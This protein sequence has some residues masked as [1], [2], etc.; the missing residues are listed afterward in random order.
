MSEQ[1]FD[2]K[3][4]IGGSDIAAVLGLSRWCTPLKLWALKTGV[5]PETDLSDNEAVQTGIDLE[6]YVAHRFTKATGLKLRRDSRTV[7][8]AKYDFLYGHVDRILIGED[9]IYEGKTTSAYNLK[10][11]ENGKM[12]QEYILQTQFYCGLWKK[13]T[14][15]LSCLIGGQ[16]YRWAKIDFDSELF[17]KMIESAATFWN[18]FVL[19]KIAPMACADDNEETIDLLY[20]KSGEEILNLHGEQAQIIDQLVE[21]RLGGLEQ[22]KLIQEELDKIEAQ[23]KMIIGEAEGCETGQFRVSWKSQKKTYPDQEK[24]KEDGIFETYKKESSFRVLRTK[25]LKGESK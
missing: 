25:L 3:Q 23:I 6:E 12:P 19:K 17:D 1:T 5:I 11:W 7:R 20:P 10:E 18:Q 4:G 2:R 16:K 14:G 22:N 24:M 15:Y 8:H 13:K 9:A 21:E